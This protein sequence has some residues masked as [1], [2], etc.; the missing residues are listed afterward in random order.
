MVTHDSNE[1]PSSTT[2]H[3]TVNINNQLPH[4]TYAT[5]V[6][7]MANNIDQSVTNNILQNNSAQNVFNRKQP[8]ALNDS[9]SEVVTDLPDL[10]LSSL[11]LLQ[12]PVLQN[13]SHSFLK[14]ESDWQQQNQIKANNNANLEQLDILLKNCLSNETPANI[15]VSTPPIQEPVVSIQQQTTT[16]GMNVAANVLSNLNQ[17]NSNIQL[18]QLNEPSNLR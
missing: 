1:Q 10:S 5:V 6:A 2:Q 11:D 7:N 13:T 3:S 4:L 18:T 14:R 17:N 12:T 16:T 9:L 8:F 15:A